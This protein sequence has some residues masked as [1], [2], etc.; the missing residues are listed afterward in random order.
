MS[1]SYRDLLER[2]AES[3][4][5]ASSVRDLPDLSLEDLA[6]ALKHYPAAFIEAL[7]DGDPAVAE[8]CSERLSDTTQKMTERYSHVGLVIVGAIRCYL[9]PLILRDVQLEVE[10][11]RAAQAI[12]GLSARS[13]ERAAVREAGQLS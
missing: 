11:Q 1:T 3:T 13:E 4:P 12:E 9:K 5:D 2:I 7:A 8:L 10:R 6:A